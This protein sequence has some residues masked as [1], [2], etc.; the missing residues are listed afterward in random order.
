MSEKNQKRSAEV[1]FKWAFD[2]R[3]NNVI[4]LAKGEQINRDKLFLSFTSHSPGLCTHGP[5]GLNAS[6]KGIGFIP[7]REF[8]EDILEKYLKH[9]ESYNSEDK[10]YG[11]RGLNLLTQELYNPDV[12]H[13]IDFSIL[14]CDTFPNQMY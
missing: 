11:Q 9:I 7:K 12:R 10:G 1:F 13:K 14:I 6:I 3:A 5:A 4:K 2:T 8:M